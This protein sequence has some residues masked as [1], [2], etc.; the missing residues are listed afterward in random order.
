M[1]FLC[2]AIYGLVGAEVHAKIF[3]QQIR[4]ALINEIEYKGIS[5]NRIRG[6]HQFIL[7]DRSIFCLFGTD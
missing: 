2:G 1:V 3:S 4:L 6:L 7:R 5:S